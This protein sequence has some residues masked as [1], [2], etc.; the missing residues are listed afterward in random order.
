VT[1]PPTPP[2]SPRAQLTHPPLGSPIHLSGHPF[3]SRVTHPPLGVTDGRSGWPHLLATRVLSPPL[4]L[5]FGDRGG[6]QIHR[7]PAGNSRPRTGEVAGFIGN[8]N[9]LPSASIIIMGRVGDGSADST[10]LPHGQLTPREAKWLASPLG[11]SGALPSALMIILRQVGDGSADPTHSA[12]RATH[13]LERPRW[14]DSPLGNSSALPSALMII[15]RQVGDGSADPTHLAPQ[16]AGTHSL[17]RRSGW[18]H[19]LATR[20]LSPSL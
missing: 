11:N 20:V 15:L 14:L 12:P 5:F 9:A 2:T 13:P 6:W 18:L 8:S 16:P 7:S 3:T 17:E 4:E 10:H 19:L 1:D